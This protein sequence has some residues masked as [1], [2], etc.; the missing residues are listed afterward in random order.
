MREISFV[1]LVA[2]GPKVSHSALAM[3]VTASETRQGSSRQP[4]IQIFYL[5]HSSFHVVVL[6]QAHDLSH[7]SPGSDSLIPH[8]V[9]GFCLNRDTRGNTTFG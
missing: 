6:T 8:V 2:Y 9:M 1:S 3:G 5:L 7:L 4:F